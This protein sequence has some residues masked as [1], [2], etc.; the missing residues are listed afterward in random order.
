VKGIGN[1]GDDDGCGVEDFGWLACYRQPGVQIYRISE[2]LPVKQVFLT[3]PRPFLTVNLLTANP[4][5]K[6]LNLL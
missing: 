3:K 4:I 6:A 2:S 5:R 1:E